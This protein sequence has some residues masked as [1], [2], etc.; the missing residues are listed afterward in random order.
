M[1]DIFEQGTRQ[2]IHF[3][4][5]GQIG[6]PDVW[7]LSKENLAIMGQKLELELQSKTV[8]NWLEKESKAS[9]QLK[10]KLAIVK[11]IFDVK[12]AEEESAKAA[13]AKQ[14]EKQRLLEKIHQKKDQALDNLSLEEL[15]KQLAEL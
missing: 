11:Y 15:E 8:G 5:R 3:E 7:K 13:A 14:A 10:L 4:F 1:S 6:I 2:D 9:S 12:V